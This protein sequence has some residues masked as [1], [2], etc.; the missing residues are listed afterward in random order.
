MDIRTP[1]RKDQPVAVE[2]KNEM[3]WITLLDGRVIGTPL[4]WYKSL[5][6]ASAKEIA[7]FELSYDGTHWPD[8]DEDL[9]I[10]GMLSGAIGP[11]RTDEDQI[12]I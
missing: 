5:S 9:S 3:L 11:D 2:V 10:R 8:L 1:R 4:E 6:N 7:N 12:G